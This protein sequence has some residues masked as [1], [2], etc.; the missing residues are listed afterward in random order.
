ML[1]EAVALQ[2]DAVK[3]NCLLLDEKVSILVL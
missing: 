2:I 1:I 3:K